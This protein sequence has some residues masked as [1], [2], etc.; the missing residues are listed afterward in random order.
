[1]SD[2]VGRL[3]TREFAIIAPAT[4]AEGVLR[5][6]ER[7]QASVAREPLSLDGEQRTLKIRAAYCAVSD[8]AESSVDAVEILLRAA[9]ALRES[10]R[11]DGGPV[12]AFADSSSTRFV[13]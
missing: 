6:I 12:Q 11:G 4:Q 5:L 1:M 9:A 3:G 10:R 13:Q 2:V 8:F 7:L